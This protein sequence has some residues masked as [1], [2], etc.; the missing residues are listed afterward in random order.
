MQMGVRQAV[1][2]PHYRPNIHFLRQ[3][4]FSG[5]TKEI[6]KSAYTHQIE[7]LSAAYSASA[8]WTAN[9]ATVSP[10]TDTSDQLLHLTAANLIGQLHRSLEADFTHH[11]LKTLFH[12][13]D[14]FTVHDPLPAQQTFS[15]EGAGNHARFFSP[16]TKLGT[17]LFVYGKSAIDTLK[18]SHRFPARQTLEASMAIA[19]QHGLHTSQVIFAQQNPVAIDVGV[20]HNDVIA[21]NH[22]QVFLYH[23]KAFV[24]TP[25]VIRQLQ[26]ASDECLCPIQVGNSELSLTEAV[27]S[28]LFNSQ[29]ITL[30]NKK[31][32]IIAPTEVRDSPLA[33]NVIDRIL[34]YDNPIEKA[35]FVECQQSMQNGGGPACQR[36]R[37]PLTATEIS[38]IHPGV[39]LDETKYQQLVDWVHH[40]Y[41]DQ[42][43][44]EDLMD[45]YLIT[46]TEE[47]L[48]ALT[49]I[50]GL[51]SLYHF[52]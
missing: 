11:M 16:K 47:A 14:H 12:H 36:L 37:I 9:A 27:K 3:L 4:G 21:V 45:P 2:P 23:E 19:R 40:H 26:E 28:Y 34:D 43:S 51:G 10:S 18:T 49:Q 8:M 35:V 48:D 41:R 20:F 13:T 46:E 17:H 25:Q 24:N 50:L 15:D 6:L 7:L 31:M 30:P 39:F 29:I 1:L 44:I 33:Q 32:A 42:L 52:Q 22:E 38:K 5:T